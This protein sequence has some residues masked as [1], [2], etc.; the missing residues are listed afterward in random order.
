MA[1]N[2][3]TLATLVE[4][5]N[6]AEARLKGNPDYIELTALR[7]AIAA[8]TGEPVPEADQILAIVPTKR[9]PGTVDVAGMSQSD[10]AH[11]LLQ[12]ALGEPQLVANLVKAL[13]A[14]GIR[15]GGANPNINLS[16]ILSKDLRFRSVRYKD[17]KCWWVVGTPFPGELDAP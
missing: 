14:H 17:R 15:V 1:D 8:I 2:S 10:A 9:N 6:A 5:R 11:T 7:Q 4:L 13:N 12:K 16:S 3:A